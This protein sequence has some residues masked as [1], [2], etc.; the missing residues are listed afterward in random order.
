MA[1][2]QNLECPECG[3]KFVFDPNSDQKVI[4]NLNESYVPKLKK[5]IEV[6]AYL[7]CP[8]G[9]TKPYKVTKEY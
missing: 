9:H 5:Q 2:K 1:Q 4:S 6:T 7:E 3:A 8:N